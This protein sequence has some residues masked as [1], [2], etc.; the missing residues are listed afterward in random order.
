MYGLTEEDI[1]GHY[2]GY[3][4]GIASNHGDPRNWFP[5]HGKSMDTFRADVKKLLTTPAPTE[6][7]KYY[8]VHV[9]AYSVKSNAEN[10]LKKLKAAGFDG[11][12]SYN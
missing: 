8:H 11:Y 9:G 1:I 12:V 5:R 7:K 10:M 2:E 6:T 4:K 3:Q